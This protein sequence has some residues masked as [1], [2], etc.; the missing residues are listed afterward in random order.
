MPVKCDKK[1]QSATFTKKTELHV[2]EL[3]EIRIICSLLGVA[4][5]SDNSVAAAMLLPGHGKNTA[6][7]ALILWS[8]NRAA[9][10]T[11]AWRPRPGVLP[12][13]RMFALNPPTV[14]NESENETA[15]SGSL[16]NLRPAEST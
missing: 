2:V 8:L 16:H 12:W 6:H 15:D 11:P 14:C 3:L 4:F 9:R 5:A 7:I 13:I 10:Y 1:R